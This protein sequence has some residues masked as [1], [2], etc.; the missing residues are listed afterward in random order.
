MADIIIVALG[1]FITYW[2]LYMSILFS[3]STPSAVRADLEAELRKEG[4]S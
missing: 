1:A 2:C 4:W 3:L